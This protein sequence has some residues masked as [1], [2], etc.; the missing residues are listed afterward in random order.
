MKSKR[1]IK[2]PASDVESM[3]K[4]LSLLVVSMDCMGSTY[5]NRPRQLALEENKYFRKIKAFKRLAKIR[6]VLCEAYQSQSTRAADLH[7]DEEAEKLPYWKWNPTKT[8]AKG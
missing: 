1:T 2:L 7:L 6:G 3:I 8:K 5:C 4:D